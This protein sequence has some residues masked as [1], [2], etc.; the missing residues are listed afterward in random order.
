MSK[1]DYRELE[2]YRKLGRPET[3][4]RLP[5]GMTREEFYLIYP[6]SQKQKEVSN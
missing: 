1:K 3:L 5:D 4:V 6:S 2:S